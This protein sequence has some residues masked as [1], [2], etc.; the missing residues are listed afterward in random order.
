MVGGRHFLGRLHETL[1]CMQSV[2]FMDECGVHMQYKNYDMGWRGD[3][4]G[5]CQSSG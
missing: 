2:A 4:E 5:Q 1:D 3:P